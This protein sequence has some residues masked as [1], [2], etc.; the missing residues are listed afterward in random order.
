MKDNA[1]IIIFQSPKSPGDCNDDI[2]IFDEEKE[3]FHESSSKLIRQITVKDEDYSP[4]EIKLDETPCSKS[5][6]DY[7]ITVKNSDF[8]DLKHDNFSSSHQAENLKQIQNS[9]NYDSNDLYFRPNFRG[10]KYT[11][12]SY[13]Q[14]V[15]SVRRYL[16]NELR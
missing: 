12:A 2:P 15:Q 4:E 7:K 6:Y 3:G 5:K 13:K 9:T 10:T 1:K 11:K 16:V 8:G 14:R